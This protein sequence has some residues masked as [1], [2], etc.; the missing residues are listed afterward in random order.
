[1]HLV[2]DEDDFVCIKLSTSLD[3]QSSDKLIHDVEEL[4][5]K[6]KI[7]FIIDFEDVE[8]IS[9]MGLGSLISLY[10]D[11]SEHNGHFL[12]F[13]IQ[14]EILELFY[15]TNLHKRLVMC[16]SKNDAIRY[17]KKHSSPDAYNKQ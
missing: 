9:R 16:T 2:H 8:Y 1:M 6:G 5:A 13:G 7:N 3:G 10:K 15:R 17:L 11:M 14:E 12:L 4:I